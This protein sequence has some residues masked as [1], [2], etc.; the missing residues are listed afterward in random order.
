MG[1]D[2]VCFRGRT[3][4]DIYV[5][6]VF[7]RT[8][9]HWQHDG[10]NHSRGYEAD[11]NNVATA[12]LLG[13]RPE[14]ELPPSSHIY[15]NNCATQRNAQIIYKSTRLQASHRYR[16]YALTR[17]QPTAPSLTTEQQTRHPRSTPQPTPLTIFFSKPQPFTIH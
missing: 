3:Q 5:R 10:K 17:T 1:C 16:K 11:I 8:E 13:D 7:T 14:T 9:K 15:P 4:K 12:T 6:V 2:D